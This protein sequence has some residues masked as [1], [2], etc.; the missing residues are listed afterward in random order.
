MKAVIHIFVQFFL[1]GWVSFGGPAAHIGY[2]R[3]KFVEQD[4]WLDDAAYGRLVAL[5][6]FLPGPGSSQVGFALGYRKAGVPGAIAAFLGFTTP[7]FLLMYGLSRLGQSVMGNPAVD[8]VIFGLKLLAVVVVTDAVWGMAGS[9]CKRRLHW[10]LACVSAAVLLVV[11]GVLAQ[12]AVLAVA[13][14][15]SASLTPAVAIPATANGT[16]STRWQRGAALAL[17]LA[18]GLALLPAMGGLHQ[19]Y[20]DFFQAGA[21][22]FGG[23]HVVLPLLQETVGSQVG[24]ETFLTGYAAAQAVPGPM[25]TLA[26]FLG[27]ELAPQSPLL[28]ALV[29]T[30]ALFLPGLLLVLVLYH[31]WE[32]LA[33]RPKVAAAAA[34]I[35]AAVVG[36]LISALFAPVFVTAVHGPVEMAL[37]ILGLFVLRGLKWPIWAL[38]AFMVGACL[39]RFALL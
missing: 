26:T 4:K 22:V 25:F 3:K 35:N 17:A 18:L 39:L 30:L 20:K 36:L 5:S 33:S 24:A 6:Q 14:L 2:Y 10:G 29:A 32:A 11:P 13:A 38:I 15:L 34:G 16:G 23:G 31:G 1:L 9:F 27:A 7:S 8:A 21:L 37:V 28:G 12:L 19:I